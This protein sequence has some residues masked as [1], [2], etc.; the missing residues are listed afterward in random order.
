MTTRRQFLQSA[1]ALAAAGAYSPRALGADFDPNSWASVRDQFDLDPDVTNLSTFLLASHPRGVR[2]AIER[3][4]E[5]LDRD[6]E[7]YLDQQEFSAEQQVR[8]AA[9]AYLEVDADEL[10]LTDSTTMGLGLV[11]AGV[12]LRPDQEVV[13]TTHDFY[14]THESLRLRSLRTGVRVRKVRLYREARTV[15]ADEV[16]S[17]VRRAV[18]PET[19]LLAVTWVHSSTGVKLP[20]R[21]IADLLRGINAKRPRKN[22]ILLSVDGVHGF[23][24]EAAT[25]AELG[26]DFLI[27][28][29]H[30]WLF[31]PRGTGLVWARRDVWGTFAPTIPTF[32]QRAILAWIRGQATRPAGIPGLPRPL[33][34]TPGGFHS[35]EHRWALSEAFD[36][37]G[38]IGRERAANRTHAL[39]AQLKDGL[40]AVQGVRLV[41]PDLA[42]LSAGLVCFEVAQR[43]PADVVTSLYDQARIVASVTP[44]AQRYVRLGPSILN[45]PD[46][47]D[48]AVRAIHSLA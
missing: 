16:V 33:A 26:C 41:T 8:A 2:D 24:V 27:S 5:A 36:F 47:V 43:D 21:T 13:T 10:A 42:D 35:F 23:G 9:A 6:A 19:R 45:S 31:G 15:S 11:Y 32:D 48:H 20:I 46:E 3:H 29:C 18:R 30:K 37:R 14:S 44:Y 28:G 4:R 39:A 7:R 25:P 22:R 40:R 17:A 12:G 1:A 38:Q 34:L